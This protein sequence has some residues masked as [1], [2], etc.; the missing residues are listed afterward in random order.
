MRPGKLS[1][2]NKFNLEVIIKILP[3]IISVP[4]TFLS[5][6]LNLIHSCSKG[7]DTLFSNLNNVFSVIIGVLIALFGILPSISESLVMKRIREHEAAE[8]LFYFCKETLILSFISLFFTI[9]ISFINENYRLQE[10]NYIFSIW[11]F[12]ICS[13]LISSFRTVLELLKISFWSSNSTEISETQELDKD[14][15]KELENK[16]LE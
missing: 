11:F 1:F 9:A 10:H 16:Y 15:I 14:K 6:K 3:F 4:L 7:L 13:S 5:Y 12:I 2:Q 8:E